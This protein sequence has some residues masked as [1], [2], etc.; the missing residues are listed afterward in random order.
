MRETERG[1]VGRG[2]GWVGGG[3][4]QL[5]KEEEGGTGQEHRFKGE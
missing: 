1:A 4:T 3:H 2:E 5:L